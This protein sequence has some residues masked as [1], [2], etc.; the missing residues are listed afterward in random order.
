MGRYREAIDAFENHL[1]AKPD[2]TLHRE[3]GRSKRGLGVNVIQNLRGFTRGFLRLGWNDGQNESLAYTE[4]DNTFDIGGDIRGVVSKRPDDKIGLAVVSK[5]ALIHSRG[6]SAPRRKSASSSAMAT[7]PTRAR[8]SS[9]STT[10]FTSGAAP[11]SR[12]MSSSSRIPGTT[13]IVDRF[14]CSRY[15]VT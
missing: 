1:D 2:V 13:R 7:S 14:G 9:S 10:T 11:S 6:V 5:R 4:I 3:A 15:A 12:R 8:P